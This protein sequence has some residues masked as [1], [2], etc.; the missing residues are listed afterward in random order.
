[1]SWV[2]FCMESCDISQRRMGLNR[3]TGSFLVM[4]GLVVQWT[5]S[6]ACFP[7]RYSGGW[8]VEGLNRLENGTFSLIG[9]GVLE[10]HHCGLLQLEMF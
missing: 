2:R 4:H 1:V 5:E 6:F 9:G 10:R 8:N 3:F 7:W